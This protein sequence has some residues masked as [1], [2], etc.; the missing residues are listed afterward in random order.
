MYKIKVGNMYL[1]TI[2]VTI[3]SKTINN[4]FIDSLE[5]SSEYYYT[6]D[7]EEEAKTICDKLYI[8]LGVKCVI[9]KVG[10]EDE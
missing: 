2:Y 1:Q 3:T 6:C 8:V 7:T 9:E 5:F 10:E 4:E